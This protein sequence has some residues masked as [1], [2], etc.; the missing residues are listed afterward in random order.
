MPPAPTLVLGIVLSPHM[1]GRLRDA[2]TTDMPALLCERFPGVQWQ[3][4]LVEEQL[5]SPPADSLDLLESARD[6]MLDA[7]WDVA[8]V[9]TDLPLQDGRRALLTQSSPVHSVG[10]IS[11]PGL[12]AVHVRNKTRETVVR[13]VGSLLGHDASRPG[14]PDKMLVRRL[15]QL[16]TDTPQREGDSSVQFAARVIGGNIRVLLGMVRANQPWRL[17][18]G[19]TR[20]LT[21][22]LATGVLVLVT[23]DMWLLSSVYGP[24]RLVSLGVLSIAAVSAT[25]VVG[26][27]LWERPRRRQERQQVVLFNLATV[28]TV[29]IGVIVFYLALCALSF[30]AT[31]LL[32]DATVI[33]AVLERPVGLLEYGKLAWLT[34][35][36]ATVG[37]AL[38]AGL[39]TDD[40]VRAAAYTHQ[41]DTAQ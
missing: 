41:D 29:L 30:L 11:V 2:L 1:T 31:L 15:Q 36:L 21:V 4:D 24:V 39:E 34:A 12:G 27:G 3:V 25:L 37:S 9:L 17:A 6:R 38:G 32:L 8:V 33:A 14:A 20:A 7:D 23:S 28:A 18:M 10:L 35:T 40:A 22:A 26:G 19:L 16:T 13:L 5:V